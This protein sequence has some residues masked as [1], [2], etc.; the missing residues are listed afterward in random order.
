LSE[1]SVMDNVNSD[2][3]QAWI[4]TY[5]E[6]VTERI[7]QSAMSQ[8][9]IFITVNTTGKRS[10]A[11]RKQAR[12]RVRAMFSTYSDGEEA[13]L[14]EHGSIRVP[15]HHPAMVS[16]WPGYST[17]EW[18][19]Q[20]PSASLPAIALERTLSKDDSTAKLEKLH[21]VDLCSAPGGKTAQ[22]CSFGFGKVTALE[23]SLKR[24][25]T[26]TENLDRL[27]MKERCDIVVADGREWRPDLGGR[28]DAVLL[29][30][31][32]SATGVGSRRPD[33]LRKSP[34]LKE[35]TDL[36]RQLAI[37]AIDDLLKDDG[38]LVYATC[39]LLQS[40]CED[41][42]RWLLTR[43]DG[44]CVENVPFKKGEIPGFDSAIDENGW[45]RVIPGHLTGALNQ[46]DGFFVAR[47]RRSATAQ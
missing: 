18:W 4:Q 23:V 26:L 12:E 37:H 38:V 36:Q 41:Q 35:I 13:E 39:S 6:Q 5:G 10:E 11:E 34:D 14:L 27:G 9:P 2:L 19:V 42:V 8:S 17:G 45:L 21:V 32:C 28:V 31:P 16:K 3:A 22:L 29:D 1:T 44:P 25:K 15:D 47:L 46:C 20:D 7:V 30:A 33:V 40:E 24:T 43:K